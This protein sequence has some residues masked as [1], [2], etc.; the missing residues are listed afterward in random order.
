MAIAGIIEGA[1][2]EGVEEGDGTGAHG[3]NVPHD[4]AHAGGGSL[5]GFNGGWVVVGLNLEDHGQA[6]AYVD[7][8]CVLLAKLQQHAGAGGGEESQQ[9]L[10]VLVA[11]MFAPK[12]A[13]DAEFK[14]VRLPVEEIDDSA[15]LLCSKGQ[16]RQLILRTRTHS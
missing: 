6:I 5:E 12:G 13:E 16:F 10:G 11:A 7:G 2:S 8:S 14:V 15:I 9:G 1:E 4:T 3:E